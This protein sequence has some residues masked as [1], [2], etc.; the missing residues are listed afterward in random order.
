MSRSALRRHGSRVLAAGL[1]LATA[2]VAAPTAAHAAGI[3]VD[4]AAEAAADG[5]CSLREALLAADTDRRVDACPAGSG[6]DEV[7]VPRQSRDLVLS[8]GTLVVRSAVAVRGTAVLREGAADGDAVAPLLHVAAGASVTLTGL[9]LAGST[10]TAVLNDGVLTASA[11]T[12]RDGRQDLDVSGGTAAVTNRGRATLERVTVVGNVLRTTALLNAAGATMSLSGSSLVDNVGEFGGSAAVTNA[13]TLTVSS[14]SQSGSDLGL[15]NHGA[16]T[17]TDSSLRDNGRQGVLN[18]GT[19][20]L[21][22]TTV[23]DNGLGIDNAGRLTVEHSAVRDNR[24]LRLQNRAG[25][26][27]NSGDLRLRHSAV[28]GNTGRGTGGVRSRGALVLSDVTVAHNTADSVTSADLDDLRNPDGAGGLTISSGTARLTNVT[29]ARNAYLADPGL[30]PAERSSGGMTVLSGTV[31]VAN[32]VLADNTHDA[33]V[34]VAGRDCTGPLSSRG[35]NLFAPRTG[36]ATQPATGDTTGR[37]PRLGA[38]ADNG[39][40]TPTL[41]PAAASPLVDRGSPAV[42]GSSAADACTTGDVRGVRRPV[43]GNGDGIARCDIGAVERLAA[44]AAP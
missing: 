38:L 18:T 23:A 31:T 37:D 43:D 40:R 11:I 39:G 14:T 41:L 22:R 42:P 4:T 32:S 19:A 21:V 9:T 26:V 25:G 15:V 10:S 7:V 5:R 29:L 27:E 17:V 2:G 6:A 33:S 44:P 13:G 24:G 3:T 28:V 30:A 16:L 1:V 8:S 34:T 20:R 12:V 35:Y 36:C